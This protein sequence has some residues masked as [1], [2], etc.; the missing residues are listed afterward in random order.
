MLRAIISPRRYSVAG[1]AAV[2]V[3]FGTIAGWALASSAASAAAVPLSASEPTNPS[4][5]PD[6]CSYVSAVQAASILHVASVTAKEAP[7]GP[8]CIFK[9]KRGKTEVTLAVEVLKISSDVHAMKHVSKLNIS[10]HAAYCGTLGGTLL[11]VA[12]T[13][14]NVLVVSAPCTEAR[15]FAT[16]ALRRI[17]T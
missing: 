3:A 5:Q 9:P 15:A 8:T 16:T 4:S 1:L 11:L 7:L 17:K 14:A 6:P 10:G 13:H 12:L 2:L